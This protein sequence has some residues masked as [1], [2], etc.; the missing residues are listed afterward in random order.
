M[1]EEEEDVIPDLALELITPT[2]QIRI[3]IISAAQ[4]DI[5][6]RRRGNERDFE[7]VVRLGDAQGGV[8]LPE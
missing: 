3:A 4:T 6:P 2:A 7:I 5:S 8:V 1:F